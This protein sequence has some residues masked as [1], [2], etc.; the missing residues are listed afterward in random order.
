[1]GLL[2]KFK[3]KGRTRAVVL[4]LDGVP[5]SLLENKKKRSYA[6]H[7]IDFRKRLS[8]LDEYLHP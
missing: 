1:M 8:W 2:D 7:D 5:Y 6:Q 4:G 3:K